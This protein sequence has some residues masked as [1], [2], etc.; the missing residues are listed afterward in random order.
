[1]NDSISSFIGE[2][3]NN[4]KFE[5]WGGLKNIGL[6]FQKREN[7]PVDVFMIKISFSTLTVSSLFLKHLQALHFVRL[8]LYLICL[9]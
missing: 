6:K 2:L 7:L 3:N 5:G 8:S 1:M 4:K 9:K